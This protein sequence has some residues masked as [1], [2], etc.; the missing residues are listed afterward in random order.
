MKQLDKSGAVSLISVMLF[1]LIIVIVAAAFIRNIISQ[2][3]E[4]INYDLKT[5]ASYA[6]EVGIQD[7]ARS[8]NANA[9]LLQTGKQQCAPGPGG[10]IDS[11]NNLA[12][13]CQLID[14]NPGELVGDVSP[15]KRTSTVPVQ[16]N[17]TSGGPYKLRLS[18]SIPSEDTEYGFSVKYPRPDKRKTFPPLAAWHLGDPPDYPVAPI[19]PALRINII[20]HPASGTNLNRSN[21]NQSVLIF[22]PTRIVDADSD[23]TVTDDNQKSS[24]DRSQFITN[25][26]CGL[27]DQYSGG[28]ACQAE[29][30]LDNTFNLTTS[31]GPT[32]DK[33]YAHIAAIYGPSSWKVELLDA[34]GVTKYDLINSQ[35][36]ID[37]TGRSGNVFH[38]VKQT[39]PI[40][41]EEL[42]GSDAALTIGDGICKIYLLTGSV[43]SYIPRTN[44]CNPDNPEY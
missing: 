25:A 14:V 30:T 38:R 33:L 5:Q 19:H 8:L 21:I 41:G 7:A 31:G 22:N 1:S 2:Q 43:N 24:I 29:V 37:V 35:A 36:I 9:T 4:A 28:Y 23:P 42:L 10:I 20:T 40:Q 44:V 12:Y 6:A 27:E 15:N 16:P 18:W 34:T 17:T 3:R 11:A 39:L 26:A 32:A 13:T